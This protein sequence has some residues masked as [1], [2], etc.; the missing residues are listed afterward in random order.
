MFYDLFLLV[1]HNT[2]HLCLKLSCVQFLIILDQLHRSVLDKCHIIQ[3]L[4]CFSLAGSY[5]QVQRYQNAMNIILLIK[6]T[7]MNQNFLYLSHIPLLGQWL[8][9][10]QCPCLSSGLFSQFCTYMIF[11]PV[12]K[13]NRNTNFHMHIEPTK[14]VFYE[15]FLLV[16][17]NTLH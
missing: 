17:Y 9:F 4:S 10:S 2:L 7:S 15:L 5:T 11:W 13:N 12:N 3:V 14:N 6:A 8:K 16:C 1:W